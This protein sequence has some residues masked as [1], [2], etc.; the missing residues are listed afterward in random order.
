MGCIFSVA[1]VYFRGLIPIRFEPCRNNSPKPFVTV[2]PSCCMVMLYAVG[3][4]TVWV[5]PKKGAVLF[6][7]QL[8]VVVMR[9]PL[10]HGDMMRCLY[11]SSA[12]GHGRTLD[13]VQSKVIFSFGIVPRKKRMRRG[14][15]CPCGLIVMEY[16]MMS[17][18]ISSPIALSPS[19][20]APVTVSFLLFRINFNLSL[21]CKCALVAAVTVSI[22]FL[23]GG[24]ING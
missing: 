6:C 3:V 14:S 16:R 20:F 7:F 9:T 10:G 11:I 17:F 18:R 8:T 15:N 4:G 2:S 19:I 5:P 12:F 24:R 13:L 23:G 1:A 21:S 22:A